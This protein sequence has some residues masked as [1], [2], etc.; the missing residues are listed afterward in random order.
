MQAYPSPPP[1]SVTVALYM[2]TLQSNKKSRIVVHVCV[3][4]RAPLCSAYL[5]G[6]VQKETESPEMFTTSHP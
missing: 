6:A 3:H 5:S 1:C 4:T 2:P